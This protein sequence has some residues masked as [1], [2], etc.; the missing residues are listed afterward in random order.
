MP[1]TLFRPGSTPRIQ[2]RLRS[3]KPEF[4]KAL[5]D[6]PGIGQRFLFDHFIKILRGNTEAFYTSGQTAFVLSKFPIMVAIDLRMAGCYNIVA[7][8]LVLLP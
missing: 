8:T 1:G 7:F 3:Q 2:I 6:P 5:S 4:L